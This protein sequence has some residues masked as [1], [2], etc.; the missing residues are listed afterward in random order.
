MQDQRKLVTA[1]PENSETPLESVRGWVTP[2]RLFFV[3]NHFQVPALSVDGWRLRIEGCV[4]RPRDWTWDE[5]NA[6]PHRTVFATVECA[7]NGRSFLKPQVSGVQ[8][9]AGAIGHAEWT[10]VPVR[11]LLQEAGLKPEAVEVV[12]E[13][14]DEGSEPDHPEAMHFARSLPLAKALQPETLLATRMNGELLEPSHGFPLRLFVPGW[15][16]VASVKWLS[17]IE[18]AARPFQGYFQTKKYTVQEKGLGGVETVAVGAMA[19]KSEIIRPRGGETLPVGTNRVFGVA[20]AGEE[21]VGGVEVSTDGGRTWL[22]AELIGLRAPYS[23]TLWEYLWEAARPGEHELMARAKSAS[24]R[25]QPLAHEPLNGGYMIHFVRPMA[26]RVESAPRAAAQRA[27]V[28]TLLYDMNAFAEENRRFP[29]DVEME[30]A[31]GAGI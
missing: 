23:W 17:R 10:G 25:I 24:G 30:C 1:A 19:V 27:D 21:A 14:A 11:V 16:G 13:G 29:L 7:G 31:A 9:G 4:A 26:V 15:Y 2:N 18:A 22:E 6:L 12:F 5:I 20:W 28:E 8:W 3:R